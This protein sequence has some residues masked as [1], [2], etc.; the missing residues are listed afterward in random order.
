MGIKFS[1]VTCPVLI[2]DL[3]AKKHKVI[4]ESEGIPY[5]GVPFMIVSSKTMDCHHGHDRN[6]N[7]KVRHKNIKEELMVRPSISGYSNV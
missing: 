4:W 6:A 3:Y 2:L 7:A 1:F 5:S